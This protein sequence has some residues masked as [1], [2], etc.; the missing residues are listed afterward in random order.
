MIALSGNNFVLN[1][2]TKTK[3]KHSS[4]KIINC[5]FYYFISDLWIYLIAFCFLVSR[6]DC[7]IL[8]LMITY[9]AISKTVSSYEDQFRWILSPFCLNELKRHISSCEQASEFL[10]CCDFD[11]KKTNWTLIKYVNKTLMF[12]Q[13]YVLVFVFYHCLKQIYYHM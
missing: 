5:L 10:D 9:G 3:L 4:K 2:D 1:K 11:Q 13:N 8:N 7:S 6:P 12:L